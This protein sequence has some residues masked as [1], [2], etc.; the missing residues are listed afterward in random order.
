MKKVMI[1]IAVIASACCIVPKFIGNNINQQIQSVVNQINEQPGSKATLVS[2]DDGWFNSTIIINVGYDPEYF[3]EFGEEQYSDAPS[4]FETLGQFNTDIEIKAQHGPILTQNGLSVGMANWTL[5]VDNDV[6]REHLEYAQ[7]ESLYSVRGSVSLSGL[8]TFKDKIPTFNYVNSEQDIDWQFSG[9]EGAGLMT[10]D[11]AKYT[12]STSQITGKMPFLDIDMKGISVDSSLEQNWLEI[13]TNPLYDSKGVFSIASVDATTTGTQEKTSLT[14]LSI[15]ATTDKNDAGSLMDMSISYKLESLSAKD[16]KLD[17][18]LLVT[19]VN[20]IEK[21]FME[22][23]QQAA[24]NPADNIEAI[25]NLVQNELITQLKADPEINISAFSGKINDGGFEGKVLTKLVGIEEL[26]ETL[27]DPKFWL[28]HAI[29]DADIKMDGSVALWSA[30]LSVLNQLK[31]NPDAAQMS[32]EELQNIAS[33]QA[34]IVLDTIGQ[35][36]MLT[37]TDSGYQM[38][39][40]LKDGQAQLNGNPMPLPF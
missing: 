8:V 27:E 2:L 7:G 5:D 29:A 10:S 38:I 21:S 18:I 1:P 24:Q 9:W 36:G 13:F 40:S 28:S 6:F 15:D 22:A 12:G 37:E 35:Q 32:E 20:N 34:Q 14:K 31:A 23:Y 33:Q 25:Q 39:F 3:A 11:N 17:N 30:E 19:D 26:P 4:V 16:L